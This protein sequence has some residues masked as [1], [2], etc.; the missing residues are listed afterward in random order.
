MDSQGQIWVLGRTDDVINIAAHRISTM[1][2]ESAAA[3]EP[4]IAEV[5]VI[6]VRDT[7]RGAV[8]VAFVTLRPGADAEAVKAGVASAVERAIGGIAR[9][10]RVYVS[11]SLPKTRA[12]KIMR[13]LLREAAETG[14]VR[15]DTTGLEDQAAVDAVLTAVKRG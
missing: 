13:R 15:G 6:G 4:G 1:E 12:G 9:L 3:K 5:A 8:P 7:L 10:G 2:I 14:S 11:S